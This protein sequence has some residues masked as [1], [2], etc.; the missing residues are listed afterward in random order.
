MQ[1]LAEQKKELRKS[2]RAARIS[3]GASARL[4]A[5]LAVCARLQHMKDLSK[6]GAVVAVYLAK[7]E[8]LSLDDFIEWLLNRGIT[9]AVPV[10]SKGGEPHFALLRSL[11]NLE[12]GALEL[13]MAPADTPR[14]PDINIDAVLFPGLAYDRSGGRL[15]YGG[16]W[17]D[18]VAADLHQDAQLIGIGFDCQLIGE[19]PHETHDV[20]VDLVVTEAQT[21]H[22]Q[23]PDR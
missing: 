9:V 15:G 10:Y 23:H 5:S 4:A 14:V 11:D 13:R 17:Y 8:E 2:M 20:R 16:G 1:T 22:A 3:L 6:P 12:I 7:G 21:I 19:V 18:K